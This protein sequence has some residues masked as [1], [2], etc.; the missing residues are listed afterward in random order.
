VYLQSINFKN[1][2]LWQ[3]KGWGNLGVNFFGLDYTSL[4]F[5]GQMSTGTLKMVGVK[6]P[7]SHTNDTNS[8]LQSDTASCVQPIHAVINPDADPDSQHNMDR[9]NK[10]NFN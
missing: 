2:H 7:T 6:I 9:W 3:F 1:A 8:I 4:G 10:F 5:S